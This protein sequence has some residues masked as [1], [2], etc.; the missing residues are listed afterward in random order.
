MNIEFPTIPY[1]H[2]KTGNT[3]YVLTQ[4]VIECTNGREEKKY[5]IYVNDK[6][7]LFCRESAEFDQK[8]TRQ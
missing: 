2:N 1:T 5:T 4:N 3:Y 8:F 6:G 7:Q